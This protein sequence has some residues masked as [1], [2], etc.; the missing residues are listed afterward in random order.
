[1]KSQ[2]VSTSN[3]YVDKSKRNDQRL[4]INKKG[5]AFIHMMPKKNSAVD[6]FVLE[7]LDNKEMIKIDNKGEIFLKGNKID[8]CC[9]CN[10]IVNT[11]I[12]NKDNN[13]ES[14]NELILGSWKIISDGDN[15]LIQ[16]MVNNEWITKQHFN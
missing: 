16:K 4:E 12:D 10:N 11:H 6:L 15:L 13:I 2:Y 9:N 1:M 7:S 14:N 3:N 5:K 8:K